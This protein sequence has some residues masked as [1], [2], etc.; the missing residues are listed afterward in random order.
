MCDLS[1]LIYFSSRKVSCTRGGG[2]ATNSLD[3]FNKMKDLVPLYEGFLTYGGM[4]VREIEAMAVG[5]RETTDEA[6]VGQSPAFIKYLVDDL[7]AAGVPV[8]TPA[9]GLGAHIDAGGFL[10]HV[11]QTR[12]PG[13]RAGGRVLHHLRRARHGTRHDFQ[14]PRRPTATTSSPMSNCSASPCRA[15]CSR[16]RKSCTW[17][18]A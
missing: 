3:L 14:R 13:G 2:I 5:L 11:P 17:P 6:M 8:V 18:T 1:D 4:S 10:P 16:S 15:A 12:I 9:G 7:D